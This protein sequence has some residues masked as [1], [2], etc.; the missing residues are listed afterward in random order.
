MPKELTVNQSPSKDTA[1]HPYRRKIKIFEGS[2]PKVHS[3]L[4]PNITRMKSSSEC[5]PQVLEVMLMDKD[6]CY[7]NQKPVKL[8]KHLSIGTHRV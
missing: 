4:T 6:G 5:S 3:L 8:I 2:T 7:T 1:P